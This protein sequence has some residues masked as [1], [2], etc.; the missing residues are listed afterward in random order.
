M[1]INIGVNNSG[2]YLQTAHKR[3][4]KKKEKKR[5]RAIVTMKIQEFYSSESAVASTGVFVR[6]RFFWSG[7]LTAYI[8]ETL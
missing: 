3:E 6:P 1:F 5:E 2:N 4:R 8:G 7:R